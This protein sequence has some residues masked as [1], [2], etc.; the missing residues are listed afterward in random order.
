MKLIL[1]GLSIIFTLIRSNMAM[2]GAQPTGLT[3]AFAD[4]WRQA[5]LRSIGQL[6]WKC[7]QISSNDHGRRDTLRYPAL[8]GLSYEEKCNY[9][10]DELEEQYSS[11]FSNGSSTRSTSSGYYSQ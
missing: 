8:H 4:L 2:S 3:A 6:R 5:S 9:V 1:P 7:K 10:F 11:Y